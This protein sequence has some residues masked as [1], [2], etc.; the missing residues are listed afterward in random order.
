MQIQKVIGCVECGSGNTDVVIVNMDTNSVKV[1]CNNCGH[2]W[3]HAEP[4]AVESVTEITYTETEVG[5]LTKL[6]FGLGIHLRGGEVNTDYNQHKFYEWL[7]Q[8]KKK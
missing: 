3:W 1:V 5:E 8:N 4:I 2:I 7:E 6:A